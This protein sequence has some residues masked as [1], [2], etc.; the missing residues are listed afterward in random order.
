MDNF[1]GKLLRY[2]LMVGL[3]LLAIICRIVAG[4]QTERAWE[5][6]AQWKEL[7]PQAVGT[8]AQA[9]TP[10]AHSIAEMEA[11]N[12]FAVEQVQEDWDDTEYI[13]VGRDS[14]AYKILTLDS[15]ERVASRYDLEGDVYNP[16]AGQWTSPVGRWVPWELDETE[17][18]SLEWQ[19]VELTTLDYYVDMDGAVREE[20]HARFQS[21]FP[22]VGTAGLWVLALAV[23]LLIRLLLWP[24]REA[25]RP[26]NDVERWL[27]GIHAVWGQSI[28]QSNRVIPGKGAL[29]IRFGG[30]PRTPFTRWELRTILRRSWDIT[31][32]Q[33]LLETVEYMS[34]GPGF[35]EDMSQPAKAWQMSR[36][37][38]LLGIAMVLGWAS[39]KELVERTREIGKLVQA[40]FS[41]WEELNLGFL[42]DYARWRISQ[43]GDDAQSQI[44]HRVDCYY[45]LQKRA[46]SPYNLPWNLNLDGK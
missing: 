9:D 34:R 41:S 8:V 44:Q 30:L 12:L 39:R 24:V 10:R 2:A 7:P 29:P 32:Y 18:A 6:Y 31:N 36:C 23:I 37:T 5:Q 20:A 1:M 4:T 28:A 13:H 45:I 3:V 14:A 11:L 27:V 46:D 38:A 15:G 40:Q 35:H 17:R 16:V 21:W 43:G 19:G 33:Q 22:W 26:R 42:E 25:N